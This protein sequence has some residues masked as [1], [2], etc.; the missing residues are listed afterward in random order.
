MS[1]AESSSKVLFLS[2]AQVAELLP[3][4]ACIEAVQQALV[5]LAEGRGAQPLRSILWLPERVGALGLMPGAVGEPASLGAKIISVFPGNHS[6][7]LPSHQGVVLL[8]DPIDGRLL[9]IQDGERITA[10]RT[11]AASAVA[12]RAL[13]RSDAR[14]LAILGSGAQA[15]SHLEA[16]RAVRPIESVRVWSRSLESAE[17][18]V[19]RVRPHHDLDIAVV[20]TAREAVSNADIVCTL[21]AAREPVLKGAWLPPGIHVNGVGSCVPS[22]RELDTEVMRRAKIYCD[23][24]ESLLAEAGDFIIPLTQGKLSESDLI[25]EIGDVLRGNVPGRESDD[26]VTLFK[27]LG[28]AVEDLGPARLLFERAT[29]VGAGTWVEM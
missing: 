26:E 17:R 25:G 22:A 15:D 3:M 27:S 4:P 19:E 29:E 11:A 14:R 1:A 20:K 9:S 23:R 24:R 18:F 8:F 12:T 6:R 28:I 7:G 21:T 2:G 16:M 5:D 10:I 13:A